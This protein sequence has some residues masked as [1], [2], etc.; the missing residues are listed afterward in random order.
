MKG[1]I[2]PFL[3]CIAIAF[4]SLANCSANNEYLQGGDDGMHPVKDELTVADCKRCIA[5]TDHAAQAVDIVDVGRDGKIIWSWKP[6][7][8]NIAPAN[9]KWFNHA[10]EVKPVYN[11][12]YLLIDASTGGTALVRI[13]DKKALF[14][15]HVV[16]AHSSELL[17][18]GNIVT[19]SSVDD[20][21]A[22]FHVDTVTSP[23][24]VYKKII[25]LSKA[26]S[27]V[28]DKKRQVLWSAGGNHLYE[29][30]YNFNC[31][32][33]DLIPIDTLKL[34]TNGAHDL[35][36]VYGR[37]SLWLT[38][39]QGVYTIDMK[40]KKIS[41]IESKYV[42]HIKS[43]SSGPDDWPTIIM[44]P[45][46]RYWSDE[47]VDTQGNVVFHKD[48]MEIYKARWIVDNRFSYPK[49]DEFKVCK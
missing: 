15:A 43:V 30:R 40:T 45:T 6:K 4:L 26:H 22:V 38:T 19:A 3:C 8:S 46:F 31:K 37:D 28:W 24:E 27:V 13:A 2:G 44:K 17:P 49:N 41:P 7:Q 21:L 23:D 16:E 20:H 10:D 5:I 18:D 34:P 48:G 35:F 36:P 29:F 42:K 1:N 32:K 33:P 12:K 39:G 9:L 14:Y 25:P 47:V 11:K